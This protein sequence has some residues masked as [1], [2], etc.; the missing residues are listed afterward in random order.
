MLKAD[1]SGLSTKHAYR[2]LCWL[3]II[4]LKVQKAFLHGV[5][6]CIEHTTSHWEMLQNAK[7]AE[8]Q[9]AIAW[10]DLENAYGSVRHMLAQFALK[11]YHVPDS[12]MEL[13]FKYQERI[14]LR[15]ETDKWISKWFHLAIGVPRGC[16]GSTMVFDV[17]FQ[18]LLDLH[19]W[20]MRGLNPAPGYTL[21]STKIRIRVRAYADDV[22]TIGES[23]EQWQQSICA[24]QQALEWTKSM[25]AKATK[26]RSLALRKFHKEEKQTKF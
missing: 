5:A 25:K 1:S 18:I 3:T 9:I 17:D 12:M 26:C 16:T 20:L 19:K 14:Y 13:L 22:E 7:A 6:G 23:P 10:L 24:F 21:S 11:W 4:Q 15:V 8:R 2:S